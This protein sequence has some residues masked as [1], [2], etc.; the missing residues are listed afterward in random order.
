MLAR[1]LRMFPSL[2]EAPQ[3]KKALT[4]NL[5]AK[6]IAIE[7]AYFNGPTPRRSNARMAGHGR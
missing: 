1:L 3:I 5:S 7:A 2:P 6:N 4:Q